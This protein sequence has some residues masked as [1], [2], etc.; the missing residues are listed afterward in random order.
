M[1]MSL[2]LFAVNIT[3]FDKIKCRY[4]SASVQLENVS[5]C[6]NVNIMESWVVR[7]MFSPWHFTLHSKKFCNMISLMFHLK[8]CY[9]THGFKVKNKLSYTMLSQLSRLDRNQHWPWENMT[10]YLWWQRELNETW[11]N[12]PDKGRVG[13]REQLQNKSCKF[14]KQFT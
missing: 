11:M 2:L 10:A 5:P 8:I 6:E 1:F 9:Y 13:G 3:Y 7:V 14:L 4:I 12:A